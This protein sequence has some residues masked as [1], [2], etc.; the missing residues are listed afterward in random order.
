MQALMALLAGYYCPY[1][2]E[3][4]SVVFFFFL[5]KSSIELVGSAPGDSKNRIGTLN[6]DSAQMSCIGYDI[7]SIYYCPRIAPIN[8]AL[9]TRVLSS[10]TLLTKNISIKA[11]ISS[12]Y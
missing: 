7:G 9:A 8:L 2:I 5:A 1:P 6:L 10:R 11:L 4:F 3:T 12:F